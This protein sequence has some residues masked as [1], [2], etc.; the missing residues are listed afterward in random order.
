M[1]QQSTFVQTMALCQICDKPFIWTILAKIDDVISKW[2]TH[3]YHRMIFSFLPRSYALL[4]LWYNYF[5]NSMMAFVN[6]GV[7]ACLLLDAKPS[8]ESVLNYCQLH[9]KKHISLKFHFKNKRFHSRKLIWKCHLQ[10][11][12]HFVLASM[13]QS[14][15][16]PSERISWTRIV[17]HCS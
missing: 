16:L 15:I 12:N 11:C 14:N 7:M 4:F 9:P 17:Q 2:V 1:T 5:I 6:I 8:P 13:Y 3:I 10:N